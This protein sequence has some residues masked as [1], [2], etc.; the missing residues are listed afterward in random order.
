VNAG[1]ALGAARSHRHRRR[2]TLGRLLDTI[3]GVLLL[4]IAIPILRQR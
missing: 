1:V 2:V 3:A 4:T